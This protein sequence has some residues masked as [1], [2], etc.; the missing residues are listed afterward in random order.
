MG[1]NTLA[2]A[3]RRAGHDVRLRALHAERER[4]EAVGQEIDPQQVHRLKDREAEHRRGENAQHL[5]HVR[6][7][8]ELDRTLDVVVNA[9]ALFDRA[10]DGGEVIVC[11]HHVGHVFR[12]VRA[13]D[14]HADADVRR[15]DARRVVDAVA[16]H[17]GDKAG[18]PPGPDDAGLVLGLHAG[19]D[20]DVPQA[21][22]KRGIVHGAQLRAGDGLVARAEQTELPGDRLGGVHVVAG[23]HDGPDA[24]AAAGTDGVHDLGAHRVDHAREAEKAQ[25]LLERRG[26]RVARQR[27]IRAHGRRQHAQG[28]AGHGVIARRDLGAMRVRHGL[29]AAVDPDP[30]AQ[31][32]QHVGR[33]LGILHDGTAIGVQGAHRLSFAVKR[34]LGHARILRAQRARRQALRDRPAHERG[35][36]RLTGHGVRLRVMHRV[37]AQGHGRGEQVFVAARALRHSHAVLR[38]RAGL[39]RTDDLRA[40]ERLHGREP[41]DDRAAAAHVRHADGQHDRHDRGQPLRNG[42]DRETDGDQERVEHDAAVDRSGAQHADREHDRTDAQHEPRQDAAQLRQAQLQG[43]LILLCL[44]ERVGDV[45]HL[46]LHAGLCDDG[47]AASVDDAAA[48]IEHVAAVAETDVTGGRERVG[49]FC[50]RHA[51]AGQGGLLG[52]QARALEHTRI[53]RNGV[54]RLKHEHVADDQF[55]AGDGDELPAAQDAAVRGAQFLQGGNGLLGLALLVHAEHR[56]D[57]DDDENDDHI[58]KALVR[59][60]AR[61]GRDQRRREQHEDHWVGQLLEK[62]LHERWFRRFGEHIAPVARKARGGL[63]RCETVGR[64][65]ECVQGVRW[66]LPVVFHG[67][68]LLQI[69]I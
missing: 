50:H 33:A 4:R 68:V 42:R 35:L 65:V 31:R 30:V 45:A 25:V 26:R 15:A 44:R 5:A 49:R 27:V 6:A 11:K 64:A 59:I 57:D 51:L 7:E 28:T 3:A 38:E 36:G 13:G 8:Q 52:A 37:H 69:P 9:A 40:A 32:Q 22:G 23:D 29:G 14:A 47:A 66:W 18:I 54:A 55:L 1:K 62:A 56:V 20:A 34:R 39:I 24:G 61:D 17:G 58:G 2:R 43:R 67:F 12:H 41:A 10:D 21:A 60:R 19:V 46:R 16:G 53:G 48:E 63:R